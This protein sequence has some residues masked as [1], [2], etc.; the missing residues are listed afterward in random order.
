MHMQL[1]SSQDNMKRTFS[2]T[3]IS[4]QAIEDL[5]SF[6][7]DASSINKIMDIKID[8]RADDAGEVP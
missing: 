2:Q 8:Q 4:N 1:R 5:V 7:D 6:G 3:I